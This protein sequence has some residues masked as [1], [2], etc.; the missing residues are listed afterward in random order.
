[1]GSITR[2]DFVHGTLVAVGASVLPVGCK[3]AAD[4]ELDAPYYPPSLTGLRGSHP[5][6]NTY[7][8]DRA[9]GSKSD[10]GRTT[11]LNES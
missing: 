10:W 1:M 8:H 2:R 9:W 3:R 11:K 4:L 5:G 7:A 6:S